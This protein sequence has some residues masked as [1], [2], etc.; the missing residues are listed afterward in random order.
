VVPLDTGS[1]L[2]LQALQ[3]T[4]AVLRPEVV[5]LINSFAERRRVADWLVEYCEPRGV[6]REKA[7]HAV[8]T[9]LELKMPVPGFARDRGAHLYRPAVAALRPRPRDRAPGRAALGLA[10]GAPL[11]GAGGTRSGQLRAPAAAAGRGAD[12]PVRGPDRD[13]R[14]HGR[15]ARRSI[16]LRLVPTFETTIEV[17]KQT[18]HDAVIVG[19]LGAR[20]GVWHR[21]DPAGDLA[22]ARYL[23]AVRDLLERLRD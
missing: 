17:L 14:A 22:P 16:D 9:L 23:D 19:P 1:F 21:E 7:L 13:G 11:R 4:R 18:P 20:H 3:Q 15:G 10:A 5:D 8:R 12:R 6:D 2:W